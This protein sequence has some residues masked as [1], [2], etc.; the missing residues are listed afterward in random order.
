MKKSEL[1]KEHPIIS[2]KV[3]YVFDKLFLI[4]ICLYL[5][6]FQI[7]RINPTIFSLSLLLPELKNNYY[8]NKIFNIFI[9]LKKLII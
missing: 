2:F 7:F 1:I 3:K 4:Y 8:Q 5:F 6:I 9:K